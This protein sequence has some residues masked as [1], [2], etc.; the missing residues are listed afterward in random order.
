MFRWYH[1]ATKCYVLL[2][3]VYINTDK[4]F[5]SQS[6]KSDFQRSKW[7]TRGWTLQELLAPGLV[8][9]FCQGGKRL[10][11]KISL[12]QQIHEIT[13]IPVSA[14][15]EGSLSEFGVDERMS[16][17]GPRQTKLEEDKAYSLLGIFDV[18]MPLIYGEGE[19]NAFER[20]RNKI[21]KLLKE[22]RECIQN[23]QL[24]DPRDEKKR[25]EET[26]G[27]LLEES[28]CWILENSDFQRWRDDP[29]SR[30]LWIEAGPSKGKT[31]LFCGIINELK[32]LTAKTDLVSYF[33]CQ[34]S[35]SRIAS[36]TDVLRGLI[37]LIIDQNPLL[38]SHIRK[39]NNH[40]DNAFFEKANTWFAL[41][42]MFTNILQDPRLKK[43]Y[44]MVDALDKCAA[45]LSK[46]LDF[47]A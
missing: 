24:F 45:D 5:D 16:W 32:K 3:D 39:K 35:D 43:T 34:A 21:D 4:E 18:H 12:K 9:F 25:L 30:L 42:T 6:W 13:G 26:N 14:L 27:G 29:Q 1:N 47:I 23:L 17:I 44:L 31:M 46:L 7:F 36:A 37:Y 8:E 20:L 15:L 2:P 38:V 19:E 28:Y 40:T 22:D 11:D 33:F 41:S 10:G